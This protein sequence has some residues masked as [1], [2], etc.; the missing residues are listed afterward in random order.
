MYLF[1]HKTDFTFLRWFRYSLVFAHLFKFK[2]IQLSFVGLLVQN[3]TSLC[4]GTRPPPLRAESVPLQ[5]TLQVNNTSR[6]LDQ[7]PA[8][9][10]EHDRNSSLTRDS[11]GGLPRFHL[12]NVHITNCNHFL[13][14]EELLQACSSFQCQMSFFSSLPPVSM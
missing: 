12:W 3:A 5:R 11:S 9:D 14:P 13:S 10:D 7:Q 8:D 4:P 2:L 1:K 6:A